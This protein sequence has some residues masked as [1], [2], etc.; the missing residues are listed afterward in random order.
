[1]SEWRVPVHS[2]IVDLFIELEICSSTYDRSEGS[3]KLITVRIQDIVAV[4]GPEDSSKPG[5]I[6]LRSGSRYDVTEP[7]GELA[8]VM[9]QKQPLVVKRKEARRSS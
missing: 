8:L 4:S 1:M 7:Y 2:S 9:T 3:G 5:R 6:H